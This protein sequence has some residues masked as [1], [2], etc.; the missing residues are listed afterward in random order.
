MHS[1]KGVFYYA[2]EI[3]RGTLTLFTCKPLIQSKLSPKSPSKRKLYKRYLMILLL[4]QL[5]F[6]AGPFFHKYNFIRLIIEA[7]R[8]DLNAFFLYSDRFISSP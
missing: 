8:I 7:L 4:Q 2:Y 5:N 1:N 3:P 6:N